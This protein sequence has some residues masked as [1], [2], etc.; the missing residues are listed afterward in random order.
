MP[1]HA[2]SFCFQI[3]VMKPAFITCYSA[4]KIG[5]AFNS[6]P[7]HSCQVTFFCPSEI[8]AFLSA[9]EEPRG[10]RLSSIPNFA[11]SAGVHSSVF[12]SL[13]QFP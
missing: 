6:I 3:K 11:P 2:P 13:L 10:H 4:V 7:F 9:S 12:Q 5:I 1:F 8:C